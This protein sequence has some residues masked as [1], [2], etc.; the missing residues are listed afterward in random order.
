M[1]GRYLTVGLSELY[2]WKT[3]AHL[4]YIADES[5]ESGSKPL[6]QINLNDALGN[7]RVWRYSTYCRDFFNARDIQHP[8]ALIK[9][10]DWKH[11]DH[12]EQFMV[13]VSQ[14]H[15]WT[16]ADCIITPGGNPVPFWW[17]LSFSHPHWRR[18]RQRCVQGHLCA[19]LSVFVWTNNTSALW[20]FLAGPHNFKGLCVRA[21]NILFKCYF[22]YSVRKSWQ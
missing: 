17:L 20:G 5:C 10:N 1:L 7:Y 19:C 12:L 18:Q 21:I 2:H 6:H 11:S 16:M 14:S 13:A 4:C 22:I 15:C 8:W 9:V 3:A